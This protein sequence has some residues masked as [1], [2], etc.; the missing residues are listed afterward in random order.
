MFSD[1]PS[2]SP[3]LFWSQTTNHSNLKVF[4]NHFEHELFQIPGKS[5]TYFNFTKVYVQAIKSLTNDRYI[6]IEKANKG[7]CA[8]VW[9]R[10]DYLSKA[11]KQ[12]YIKTIYKDVFPLMRKSTAI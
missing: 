12:L 10:A 9:D 3:K 11:E 8:V 2:L 5:F 7:S 4:L 6:V 1:Q